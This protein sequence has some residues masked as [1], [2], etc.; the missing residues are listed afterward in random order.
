LG[1][2]QDHYKTL[3]IQSDATEVEIKKAYRKM[4][5]VHHPDKGGSEAAFKEV[6]AAYE[7][8]SDPQRRARFDAGIDEVRS[9]LP[10]TRST[11][12][13]TRISSIQNDPTGGMSAYDDF[14]GSPFGMG[15]SPFGFGGGFGG[16]GFGGGGFGM[17]D[18]FMG[19]MGGGG[20]RRGYGGGGYSY[21]F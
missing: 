21:G 11:R 15:G 16:G 4:A 3:G 18:M 5:I 8:L 12:A 20:G 17:E 10:R 9:A 14:G 13:L 2:I 19:G 6:S 1:G 7:I